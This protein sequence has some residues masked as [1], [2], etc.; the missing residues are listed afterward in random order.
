MRFSATARISVAYPASR[1]SGPTLE[2]GG[3][4]RRNFRRYWKAGW[5]SNCAIA[6]VF[7]ASMASLSCRRERRAAEVWA[8]PVP[9][10]RREGGRLQ[11]A[12][13]A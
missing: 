13:V 4:A 5:F 2:L 9:R 10:G 7:L 3:P 6:I 12:A 1:A 11:L 8:D